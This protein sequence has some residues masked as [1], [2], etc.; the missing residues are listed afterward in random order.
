LSFVFIFSWSSFESMFT[1]FSL[2]EFP[3]VF[4]LTHS[5]EHATYDEVIPTAR[6]VGRY[7]GFIGIMSAL[8]QGGLIRRLVPRF[9][10][11]A[12]AVAG[13]AFLALSFAIFGAAPS[14]TVV[15]IACGIMPFGF[16]LNN[17]ALQGLVSR[18]SPA[19]EQGAYMGLNQSVLSLARM[20]GPIFAGEAFDALGPRSPFFLGCGILVGCAL[21][22]AYY[23]ARFG[24]SFSR[25]AAAPALET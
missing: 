13:P 1:V 23:R 24:A 9:G 7:M 3:Q 19:D 20:T 22:A 16:G 11:T 2:R 17:P 21:L 10:E 14:W 4:G 25:A 6:I 12:L 8:I 18:A 15:I 5:I